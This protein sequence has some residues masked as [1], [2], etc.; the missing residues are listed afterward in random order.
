MD[1]YLKSL[2]KQIRCKKARPA[3]E[4]EVR[5]HIEDQAKTNRQNGMDEEEA[6]SWAV[7][8]MGDPVQAGA[9]LDRVHR[10]Q[11]AWD[12]LI[13]MAVISLISIVIH[14]VIGMHTDQIGNLSRNAYIVSTIAQT[15]IGFLL[16][17]V[18]YRL[19]YSILAKYGKICA[20]MFLAVM[21]LEV[22]VV[23][24]RINGRAYFVIGTTQVTLS[25]IMFL[26][27]PLF[28]AVLFGYRG[29]G[30]LGIGKILLFMLVPVYLA[31]RIPS[32]SFAI[33]LLFIM[34]VMLTAAVL[35]GWFLVPNAGVLAG[36]WGFL[37]AAPLAA[38]ILG[39][40]FHLFASY[41]EARLQAL[42]R[43]DSGS[44]SYVTGQLVKLA[45]SNHL[46][47]ASGETAAGHLPAYNS[48]Y[49]L[50]FV[51][52]YYGIA[53]AMGICLLLCVIA[54]KAFRIALRQGNQL[55]LMMSFGS[56]L[57]FTVNTVLNIGENFGILPPTQTFLPFFSHGGTSMAVSYILAGIVLSVYRYKNI[58]PASKINCIAEKI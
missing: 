34:A 26:Y 47:G 48:D 18:V 25:A 36:L 31:W 16:M 40:K 38:I 1:D 39:L 17:L 19:D 2:L 5:S 12:M 4:Q 27:V 9:Q 14:V 21:A 58:L 10:P 42:F 49:I 52:S 7:H 51:S 33:L 29:S 24:I 56:G 32:V 15:G 57:V 13:V 11:M 35:K 3:I 22:F 46:F 44:Y 8:D 41:Q 43:N 55:G 23:G 50:A 37:A 20:V 54:V 28:G 30:L 45:K 53:A 6:M